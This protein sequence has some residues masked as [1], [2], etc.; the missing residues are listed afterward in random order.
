MGDEKQEVTALKEQ[1]ANTKGVMQSA[2]V[3]ING[4]GDRLTAAIDQEDW[5]QVTALRDEIKTETDS[6]AAAVAN[7]PA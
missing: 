6:L 1:V 3:L 2:T 7:V 5:D 4:F